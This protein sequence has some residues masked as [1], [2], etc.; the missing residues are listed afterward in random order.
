MF[1]GNSGDNSSKRIIGFIIIV[2]AMF[3][4]TFYSVSI[5]FFG[6]KESPSTENIIITFVIVG[7]AMISAGI[8][9]KIGNKKL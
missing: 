7:G 2:W 4:T 9:E 1:Q 3:A 8:A 6:G 5:Q